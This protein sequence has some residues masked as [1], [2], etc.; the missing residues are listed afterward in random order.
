MLE[1]RG[2]KVTLVTAEEL[3]NTLLEPNCRLLVT[4][5][6]VVSKFGISGDARWEG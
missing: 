1:E 3:A 2:V 5:L 4:N 6:I